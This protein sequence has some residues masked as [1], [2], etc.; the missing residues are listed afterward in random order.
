MRKRLEAIFGAVSDEVAAHSS[1]MTENP[2]RTPAYVVAA[3]SAGQ[4]GE[5][6]KLCNESGVPLT[7]KVTGQNVGGLAIPAEGGVVLDLSALRGI[8][9][10]TDNMVAWIEPGVSWADLK[11]A[12]C[13]KRLKRRLRSRG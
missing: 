11:E 12:W 8:E 9:I 2:A 10:D 6:L 1:D 4:V 7:P 13:R 5:V 3:T